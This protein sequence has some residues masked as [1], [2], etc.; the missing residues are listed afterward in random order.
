M[1]RIRVASCNFEWMN[2]WFVEDAQPAKFRTTFER[3]GQKNNTDKTAKRVKAV[4]ETVDPD[5]LGIEEA[6]SRASELDLFIQKY[7]ST[8]GTPRYQYFL[9]ESGM[10]QKVAVLYKPGSVTSATLAPHSEIANLIDPWTADVNGDM[11]LEEYH[12]TRNPLVVNFKVGSHDLQVVALHT[13]SNFVNGGAQKWS[14]P[15]TRQEYV[16]LALTARRRN[17]TEGMRVREYLNSLLRA[18]SSRRVIVLGDLNDGPGMDYFERNYL[19]HNVT[20]I[21]VGSAFEKE[22]IFG[23]AQHDVA[24]ADRYTAV[25]DD[26]VENVKGKKLLLDHILLSPGLLKS[27][28]LRQVPGSGK[29]HHAEY[30]AQV[31]SGGVKRENRP[32]DHRPVSVELQY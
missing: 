9:G 17:A 5:I 11:W 20:D 6:P 26:F 3:D 2:D 16:A 12:F 29:I 8:G 23:H 25:F 24:A 30:K 27:T 32:S 14:N 7:L 18:N 19:A 15:Q 21:L 22:W 13:K 4:I 10:A 1:P 28:G 31:V